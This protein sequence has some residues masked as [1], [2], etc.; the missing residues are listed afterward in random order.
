MQVH[1]RHRLVTKDYIMMT[2]ALVTLFAFAFA[3]LAAGLTLHRFS[4]ALSAMSDGRGDQ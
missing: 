4:R 3:L 1:G 2:C